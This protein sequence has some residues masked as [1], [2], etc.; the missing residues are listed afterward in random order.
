MHEN[1]RVWEPRHPRDRGCPGCPRS[2]TPGIFLKDRARAPDAY[3]RNLDTRD[4]RGREEVG[5]AAVL[6]TWDAR[7]RERGG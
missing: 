2:S 7:A 3:R 4:A 5:F 1:A 6:R